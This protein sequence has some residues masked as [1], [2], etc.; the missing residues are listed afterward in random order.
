LVAA[1]AAKLDEIEESSRSA[2]L[3]ELAL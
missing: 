3:I 2:E 1:V